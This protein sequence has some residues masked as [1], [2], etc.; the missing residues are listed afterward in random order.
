MPKNNFL[1]F[2]AAWGMY[3]AFIVYGSL[4]P[5]DFQYI[6]F[7]KAAWLFGD[8]PYLKLGMYSRED[9]IANG[10]LYFPLG[11]LSIIYRNSSFYFIRLVFILCFCTILAIG[12]E[13]IQL[14]FPGRTVSLNDIIAEI[15]GSG[16][17]LLFF[18]FFRKYYSESYS[19]FTTKQ[20]Q[21]Y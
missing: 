10:I 11:C 13:F 1:I 21:G 14:Y 20:D 15:I 5:F 9:W 18:C 6:S 3:A 7:E 19:K 8:I 4:I 16:A 2:R 17:G 12:V